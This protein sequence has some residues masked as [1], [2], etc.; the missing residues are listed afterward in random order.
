MHVVQ[1]IAL[2]VF[3]VNW[4]QAGQN[5]E[6]TAIPDRTA[7]EPIASESAQSVEQTPSVVQ[8]A[9]NEPTEVSAQQESIRQSVQEES[10]RSA[11][12]GARSSS[13]T[14]QQTNFQQRNVTFPSSQRS[15]SRP[16]QASA[17]PSLGVTMQEVV[18]GTKPAVSP[19]KPSASVNNPEQKPMEVS[20]ET[21]TKEPAAPAKSMP[22]PETPQAGTTVQ[23]MQEKEQAPIVAPAQEAAQ[24]VQQALPSA[25]VEPSVPQEEQKKEQQQEQKEAAKQPEKQSTTIED[26]GIDTFGQDGGNWLLKRQALEKT[27]DVI[28]KI[29]DVFT[30]TLDLR[31]DYLV[32]RNKTDKAF[33][34]FSNTIGFELGDLN[35]LLTTL[36]TQ[37][38]AERKTQGDLPEEE[39]T[40][41]A[42]IEGKIAEL[43]KLKEKVQSITQMD[44]SLDDAIMQ[45]EKEI[46]TSNSYQ[47]RAWRNFQTIK[48]VLNDEKAEELYLQTESLLKNMQDIE[49]YLK[50]DLL[51]YFNGVITTIKDDMS[52]A[53]ETIK[54][55]EEKGI[56]LKDEVKKI[57]KAEKLARKQ[58]LQK[59]ED[60]KKKQQEKESP[61]PVEK[62]VTKSWIDSISV[63]WHYPLAFVTSAWELIT[64]FF[65]AKKEEVVQVAARIKQQETAPK[66]QE[67]TP[68]KNEKIEKKK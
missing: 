11:Q 16:S 26:E 68:E 32:K 50:G 28:E 40:L 59:I 45:L 12:G 8:F 19:A 37:L 47:A 25:P 20:Q 9:Q 61:K 51:T 53:Q 52:K 5:S 27:M 24:T 1:K 35:Q 22:T 13:M 49:T 34:T 46:N 54:A 18:Q 3:F 36:V 23:P 44:E 2:L 60:E 66:Q 7:Q 62:P 33:D 42:E 29:K 56:N 67:T 10:Q 38:K 21:Q 65:G 31:I 57:R 30:K 48:T 4:L 43:K 58:K 55:L 41:L 64:G 39:R 17:Q 14:S 6:P 15:T 63:L